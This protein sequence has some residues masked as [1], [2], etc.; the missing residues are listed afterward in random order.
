MIIYIASS[1]EIFFNFNKFVCMSVFE[2]VCL[3]VWVCVLCQP[4]ENRQEWRSSSTTGSGDETLVISLYGKHLYPQN[5]VNLI[6]LFKKPMLYKHTGRFSLIHG[7][8]T[9]G[10]HLAWDNTTAI[11]LRIQIKNLF[12][13]MYTPNGNCLMLGFLVVFWSGVFC[14]FWGGGVVCFLKTRSHHVILDA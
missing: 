13:L 11:N 4:E 6:S 12:P 14:L 9:R 7:L 5:H 10:S 8:L 1:N 2:C 3:T